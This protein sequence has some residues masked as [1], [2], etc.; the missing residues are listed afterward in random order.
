MDGKTKNELLE[1]ADRLEGDVEDLRW[2]ASVPSGP[3]QAA[4]QR[5][6]PHV[7]EAV[8]AMRKAANEAEVTE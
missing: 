7:E 3:A 8:A 6:L 4:G 1:A 5:M 2:L